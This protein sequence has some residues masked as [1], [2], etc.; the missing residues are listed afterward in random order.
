MKPA[1]SLFL[2]VLFLL[3]LLAAFAWLRAQMPALVAVH[4]NAHGQIDGYASPIK[5]V[6]VP[7]IVMASLALLTIVLPSIS[8]RGFEITPFLPVFV[9]IMLAAQAF[10]L[11]TALGILLN[12][13]GH[14][15][16][17]LVVP[18]LPMGLLLMFVGNYMGK[19][20]KNFF[21]GI[22]TPWTIASDEV[23]ERTHR[24]AGWVFML[25]GIIVV[26]ASLVNAPVLLSVSVVVVAAFIPAVYSYLVYRRVERHH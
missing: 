26:V 1:S 23:W 18:L 16:G 3:I 19:L 22:R 7:M 25:A 15:A 20:R 5:A 9:T 11:V 17:R 21:A 10:V 8:P 14:P 13:A 6:A 12:A 24:F 4:W 2:S